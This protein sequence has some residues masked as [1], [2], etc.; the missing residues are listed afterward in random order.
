MNEGVL[1][2]D[3]QA[4]HPPVLH[5]WM[6]GVGYVDASPSAQLAFIAVIEEAD[7]MQ[8]VEV[9]LGGSILAVDFERIKRLVS[10]S[11]SRGFK[12]CERAVLETREK[13]AGIVDSNGLNLAG[14]IVFPL[15]DERLSHS[16][17]FRDGPVQPKRG[18]DSMRQ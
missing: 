14:Y 6:I 4:G 9:P 17:D 2:T 3:L 16:S 15:L 7:A 13:R 11:V 5:I 8:I 1:V 10:S 18:V 12:G